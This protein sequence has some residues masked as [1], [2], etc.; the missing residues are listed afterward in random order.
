MRLASDL[1]PAFARIEALAAARALPG[2][3][4]ATSHGAPALCVRTKPF[5]RLK[6]AD[7]LV[8]L[9]PTEQKILLME[10][11]PEIYFET[12]QYVGWPVVLIRL[13]AISDE[14]LSLR[15]E[16]AWRFKA[17]AKLAA[18]RPPASPAGN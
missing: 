10:I 2:L 7:T 18:Q 1:D 13:S 6:D 3:E 12:D 17:P 14:E 8:L 15:L 4:R 9:C 11:S 16:N 5:V